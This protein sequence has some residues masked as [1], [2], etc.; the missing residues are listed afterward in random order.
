MPSLTRDLRKVERK[1]G[2]RFLKEHGDRKTNIVNWLMN[3]CIGL[4]LPQAGQ[5]CD[6]HCVSWCVIKRD[7]ATVSNPPRVRGGSPVGGGQGN[8][9]GFHVEGNIVTACIR[10][11]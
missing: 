10:L 4:P 8:S 6:D 2:P 3:V 9:L 5:L 7:E 1:R 11:Q